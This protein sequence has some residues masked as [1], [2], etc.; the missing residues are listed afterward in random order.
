MVFALKRKK[1]RRGRGK[2]P[3]PLRPA[4]TPSSQSLSQRRTARKTP[5]H[6]PQQ[7]PPVVALHP[8]PLRIFEPLLPKQLKSDP[9]TN[10]VRRSVVDRRKRVNRRPPP[11]L[12]RNLTRP[13][14]PGPPRTPPPRPHHHRT[15]PPPLELRHDRPPHLIDLLALPLA[16][17][18]VH[19]PNAHAT[20]LEH[21]LEDESP[22][23]PIR[24]TKDARP[25]RGD[26]PVVTQQH[27]LLGL[28]PAQVLRHLRRIQTD[29][30]REVVLTPRHK[31]DHR[32]INPQSIFAPPSPPPT[33]LFPP[34]S[35]SQ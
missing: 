23:L 17:P 13:P 34:L 11:G 6:S 14:P 35:P 19:R 28:G 2:V 22:V 15:A 32:R 9:A 7:E 18:E 31:S 1:I 5:P 8:V 30:Q 12:P 21:S 20:R 24:V 29:E 27:L 3:R 4:P 25:R 26:I 10:A 16:V 33:P